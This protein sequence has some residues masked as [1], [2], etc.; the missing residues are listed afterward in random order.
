MSKGHLTALGIL[1]VVCMLTPGKLAADYYD[2]FRDGVFERVD[3]NGYGYDANDPYYTNP[4]Y[5]T[6]P[7][8]WDI[9][10]P[11][12]TILKLMGTSYA[13]GVGSDAVADKAL[14]L[15]VV[16]YT[17][18][19]I[20][21]GFVGAVVNT[22]DTDPNTSPCYWDDTTDH[23][24][25][26]WCYYTNY[27]ADPNDDKGRFFLCIHT[28]PVAWTCIGFALE[29][30]AGTGPL[31]IHPHCWHAETQGID[32]TQATVAPYYSPFWNFER[33]WVDPNAGD[34][35]SEFPDP[36]DPTLVAPDDYD[37][38]KWYRVDMNSWE[39]TGVWML[40]QFTRDPNF[41]PGD[42][43]GKFMKGA[44]WKGGK[45]DWDG[46]YLLDREFSDTWWSGSKPGHN[47]G[48][49]WYKAEGVTVLSIFSDL[50]YQGGYPGDGAYDNIEARTGT[51]TNVSHSLD[52]AVSNPHMGSIAI[53]PDLLDDPNHD[54]NSYDEQR[55]YTDGTEIVLVA[56]ALSGKSF[57]EWIIFDP[58]HPGDPNYIALD[59]NTV[60]YL[61]MNAD[62]E[63]E[64]GFKCGGGVP[65]F[66]AATLLA[67]ALGVFVRHH[68]GRRG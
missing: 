2:D 8:V 1:A 13:Y 57:K 60:L 10:N 11:T 14:R 68:V 42:P 3:P 19:P 18:P 12:W 4:I 34:P 27:P 15:S 22:G 21:M 51:F 29:L 9:D 24:I 7:N 46:E 45:F 63:I 36:C 31:D 40:C 16:G 25:L 61:T 58:N 66:I 35:G 43:N 49:D 38:P 6:D 33:I 48:L 32:F 39:R 37:D 64:A 41:A 17:F 50:D 55:R 65:P 52:L 53:D 30:D 20:T 59:T 67:L 44:I 23:Y 47:T 54:P 62:W 26:A 56:E 5:W 28:D